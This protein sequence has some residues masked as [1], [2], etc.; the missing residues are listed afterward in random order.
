[1]TEKDMSQ[2]TGGGGGRG[3]REVK[4]KGKD[5]KRKKKEIQEAEA[6]KSKAGQL[7]EEEINDV[8]TN[9]EM[10]DFLNDDERQALVDIL[11]PKLS[12][13]Y[14]EKAT[15]IFTKKQQEQMDSR[16]VK[17]TRREEE[18]SINVCYTK[19]HLFNKTLSSIQDIQVADLTNMEKYLYK[20]VGM[21]LV[22]F[23]FALASDSSEKNLTQPMRSKILSQLEGDEAKD[24]MTKLDNAKSATDVLNCAHD[25]ADFGASM[26]IKSDKKREKFIMSDHI[27]AQC[28]R[29]FELSELPATLHMGVTVAYSLVN[30]SLI[31]YPGKMTQTVI[32]LMESKLTDEQLNVF[33]SAQSALMK[34]LAKEEVDVQQHI[35]NI[36]ST[37]KSLQHK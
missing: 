32:N 11:Y 26:M 36:K 23:I 16:P 22:N 8:I 2:K 3:G 12:S 37:I 13:L 29:L 6:D 17:K 35:D 31:H 10:F 25:A 5:K 21:D 15:S 19:L 14:Q 18:E 30:G 24:A 27:E 4:T 7:S 20:T 1:M 28:T 9:N 33:T 34:F